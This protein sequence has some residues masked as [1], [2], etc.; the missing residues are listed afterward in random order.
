M[1]DESFNRYLTALRHGDAAFGDLMGALERAGE[2]DDTLVI[3]L[4]DHGE[5]FLQHGQLSHAGH[6][7]EEN[8]HVPLV[9]I[10]QKRLPPG[11]HEAVRGLLDV[12]PTILHSAGRQTPA[13]WQGRSLLA[14]NRPNRTYYFA[15]FSDLLFGCRDGNLSY[16]FNASDGSHELYDLSIDPEQRR[17]LAQTRREDVRSL[18]ERVAAWVQYQHGLYGRLFAP[19]AA[20]RPSS[21]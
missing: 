10:N 13:G 3:V 15:P 18:H 6:I 14:P 12:A 16:I 9:L 5:A 2:L 17:N 21:D 4:G 7:Y 19:N 8:V 1:T 11:R 20:P